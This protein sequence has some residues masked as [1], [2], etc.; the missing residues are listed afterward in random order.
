VKEIETGELQVNGEY[1]QTFIG[2]KTVHLIVNYEAG[3]NGYVAKYR[4]W[5]T[6]M[7]ITID[8]SVY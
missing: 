6:V 5:M 3:R 2:P 8:R 7:G 1:K 4:I